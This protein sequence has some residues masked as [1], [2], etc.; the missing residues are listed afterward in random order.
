MLPLSIA[1]YGVYGPSHV[2]ASIKLY[3]VVILRVSSVKLSQ[4]LEVNFIFVSIVC[5]LSNKILF[6][7]IKREKSP[8]KKLRTRQIVDQ[9]KTADFFFSANTQPKQHKGKFF[10]LVM[11][12]W[13]LV[14]ITV[15]TSSA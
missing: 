4:N 10:Q 11:E 2:K 3:E 1:A 12:Q 9:H 14:S 6:F 7:V 5:D 15:S 8:N 13:S